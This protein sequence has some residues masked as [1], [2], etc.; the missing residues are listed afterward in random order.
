MLQ[1]LCVQIKNIDIVL[2][3]DTDQ[4]MGT[5]LKRLYGRWSF[6]SQYGEYSFLTKNVDLALTELRI[7]GSSS[8]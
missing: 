6:W 1:L 3:I 8:E 2:C 5:K 4:P 7:V